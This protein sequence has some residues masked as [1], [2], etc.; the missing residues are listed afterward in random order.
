MR[1]SRPP[2]AAYPDSEAAAFPVDAHVM[3]SRPAC[4]AFVTAMELARSLKQ[5]VGLRPSSLTSVS[6]PSSSLRLGASNRSVPPS[7]RVTTSASSSTG[8]NASYFHW[9]WI[10]SVEVGVEVVVDDVVI[11]L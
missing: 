2:R 9:L 8:R 3:M 6:T 11:V 5:P 1:Q 4:L 7:L 10:V